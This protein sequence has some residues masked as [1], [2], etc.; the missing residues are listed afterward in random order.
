MR[1]SFDITRFYNF[2]RC[3]SML[4]LTLVTTI[5]NLGKR[6]NSVVCIVYQMDTERK[7]VAIQKS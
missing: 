1:Y 4:S 5:S 3:S 7:N 2:E 6:L